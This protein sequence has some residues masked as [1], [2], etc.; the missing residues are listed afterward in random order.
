MKAA[1]TECAPHRE[2]PKL[3][4]Y[5]TDNE[6]PWKHEDEAKTFTDEFLKLPAD[7]P[8]H[9]EAAKASAGGEE[10][11]RA[12]REMVAEIYFRTTAEA[13]R[14]ADPNHM[15]LGC[16]FAGRPPLGVVAG[17]AGHADIVSINNYSPQPPLALLRDMSKAAGL[18]VL[19]SEFS[20]KGPSPGL[21]IDGSGPVLTSQQ[22][23]AAAFTR[24]AGDLMKDSVCVGYHWFKYGDNWQG[25]L[26]A[27]GTPWPE[28]TA[29]FAELSDKAEELHR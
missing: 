15:I 1:L 22:E 29:A 23:R 16:R 24:Y 3:L 19:V 28:L 26:Q 17:M 5:F 8:G 13:I 6:L 25:V 11:M 4:G 20:F 12:F 10:S 2:D 9:R 14:A 18:P 27:D 21:A 7:A